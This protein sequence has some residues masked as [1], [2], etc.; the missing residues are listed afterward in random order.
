MGS[1]FFLEYMLSQ[2]AQYCHKKVV[3]RYLLGTVKVLEHAL[4]DY[5]VTE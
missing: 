2:D 3:A 5:R 1:Q 4:M